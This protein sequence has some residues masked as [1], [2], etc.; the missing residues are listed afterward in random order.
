[1]LVIAEDWF[2]TQTCFPS[3]DKL[4]LHLVLAASVRTYWPTRGW[5]G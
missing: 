2:I 3:Y 4:I 5:S 1:M